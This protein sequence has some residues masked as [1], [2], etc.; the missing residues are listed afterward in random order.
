MREGVFLKKIFL[1]TVSKM[2]VFVLLTFVFGQFVQT[3]ASAVVACGSEKD[4]YRCHSSSEGYYHTFG[5]KVMNYGVGQ[6][7]KNNRYYW[8]SGLDGIME[9]CAKSAVED[10]VYTTGAGTPGVYTSISIRRTQTQSQ[11]MFEIVKNNNLGTGILGRTEFYVNSTKIPLNSSGALTKNYGWARCQINVAYMSNSDVSYS[12]RT[13]TIAHELGHAMGLSHQNCRQT[14]IMCQ[15][16]Y[17]RTALRA[18]ARDLR[19]INH[20][21]G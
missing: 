14:S 9:Q 1:K 17:G 12:H 8:I 2:V 16:G 4:G 18:D 11:A 20:L 7:G 10:W 3:N 5:D 15:S 6:Y 19:A 21:Y 13:G